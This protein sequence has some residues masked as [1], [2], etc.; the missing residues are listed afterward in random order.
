MSYRYRIGALAS[1]AGISVKALRFYDEIGLLRPASVDARS[2]YRHYSHQQL[3]RL[4]AIQELKTLGMSLSEIRGL[5][6][7]NG[8]AP[9]RRAFL[10]RAQ[11]DLQQ[12]I[13]AAKRSLQWIE[14]ELQELRDPCPGIP[15]V[16]KRRNGLPIAS[17]RTKLKNYEDV[18]VFERQLLADLPL[19]S[20]GKL[21]GVL[22]HRC[23]DSGVLEAEAF[24]E[25][26]RSVPRRSYYQ[27]R[28]L[29]AVTAAC[30][31]SEFEQDAEPAYDR[32]RR[33]MSTRGYRLAGAKREIY[34][35]PLL[36]IQFPLAAA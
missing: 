9:A 33:W 12:S 20:V 2:G 7:Q 30:A 31:Y 34:L 3:Q 10:E 16:A 18:A 13:H 14:S 15:V 22:W 28:E 6:A 8:A 36:E 23:A 19:G 21:R 5:V 11:R 29:E 4:A 24:V 25:L 26:K 17:V 35:G 1:L 32:I 27:L